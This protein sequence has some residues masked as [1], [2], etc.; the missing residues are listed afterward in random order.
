M[1]MYDQKGNFNPN[2]SH[3]VFIFIQNDNLSLFPLKGP[4]NT[5]R[6]YFKWSL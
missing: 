1:Y 5:A 6:G 4:H 2:L 3:F